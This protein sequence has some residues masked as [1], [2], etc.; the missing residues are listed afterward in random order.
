MLF[1]LRA[2]VGG[3]SFS[4][5]AHIA[6]LL[7]ADDEPV[8]K[9]ILWNDQRAGAES[10]RRTLKSLIDELKAVRASTIA[11]VGSLSPAQAM[12][13]GVASNNEV[14]VRAMAFLCAGHW[15]HHVRIL[16]ERYLA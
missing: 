1:R 8:R 16:R 3:V 2:G 7:D 4:S 5:A 14:T 11:L 6:V 15:E 13:K 12:R 10:A 9:A